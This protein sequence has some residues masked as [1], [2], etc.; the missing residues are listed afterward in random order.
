MFSYLSYV[1]LLLRSH[2]WIKGGSEG[3]KPW[4]GSVLLKTHVVINVLFCEMLLHLHV[5]SDGLGYGLCLASLLFCKWY[6]VISKWGIS[7][8]YV[9]LLRSLTACEI[10]YVPVRKSH[11]SLHAFIPSPLKI[12]CSAYCFEVC[13]SLSGIQ[14][15]SSFTRACWK[16][17]HLGDEVEIQTS[18]VFHS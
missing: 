3:T 1:L 16:S 14:T 6:S 5:T 18:L 8:R 10:W 15:K 7:G 4:P 2:A 12:H 11:P 17:A 13:L 9:Y